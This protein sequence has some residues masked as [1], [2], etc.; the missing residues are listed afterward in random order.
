MP[1]ASKGRSAFRK[2]SWA[3][4]FSK[5]FNRAEACRATGVNRSTLWRWLK[6]DKA[7]SEAV[8]EIEE[9]VLDVAESK[10]M[11][12][13]RAGNLQAIKFLLRSKARERGYG[14]RL[15]IAQTVKNETIDVKRL[16]LLLSDS[17]IRNALEKLAVESLEDTSDEIQDAGRNQRFEL[18]WDR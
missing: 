7:F 17:C 16:E 9:S 3:E 1:G 5:S 14:D 18:E 6:E 11:E 10:L 12:L 2:K 8:W 15:E 4:H 13:V